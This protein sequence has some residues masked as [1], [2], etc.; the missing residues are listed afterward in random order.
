MSG[1][2]YRGLGRALEERAAGEPR[3]AEGATAAYR[4][5]LRLEPADPADVHLRLAQL[6]RRR[7]PWAARRHVLDALSEA[8]RFREAH[9][10]LL[11]LHGEAP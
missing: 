1:T 5:V 9:R 11:E 4:A 10:L 6:L 2:A 3:A 8:P 7:D